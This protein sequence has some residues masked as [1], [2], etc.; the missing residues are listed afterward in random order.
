M[1]APDAACPRCG[2]AFHCGAQDEQPCWCNAL[3]LGPALLAALRE[4]HESCLCQ[5]CLLE[6]KRVD[7]PLAKP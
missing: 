5:T 6:L 7:T 2:G 1:D 4:R 3:T